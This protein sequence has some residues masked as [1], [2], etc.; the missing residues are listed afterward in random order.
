MQRGSSMKLYTEEQIL[1]DIDCPAWTEDF[2]I[3]GGI[4][5]KLS[6][7]EDVWLNFVKGRYCIANYICDNTDENGITTFESMVFSPILDGDGMRGKAVCLSDKTA[8]QKIFF[9]GYTES[10]ID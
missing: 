1:E 10:E 7:E 5:Y 9:Y 4:R 6:K 2:G 8:L 3:M